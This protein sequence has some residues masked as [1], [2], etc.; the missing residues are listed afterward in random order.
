MRIIE[1]AKVPESGL[2]APPA[3]RVFV[4]SNPTLGFRLVR[5][6]I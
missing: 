2:T 1:Y 4:G 3:E 5:R 6:Q